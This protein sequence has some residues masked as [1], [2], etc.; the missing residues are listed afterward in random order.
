MILNSSLNLKPN[1]S[2]LSTKSKT[3]NELTTII[4]SK[5]SFEFILDKAFK[6]ISGPMTAGSPKETIIFL[7]INSPLFQRTL[8]LEVL[9]DQIQVLPQIFYCKDN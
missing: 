7:F 9:V 8:Q 3:L 5:I 2:W 6:K 1:L 4:L